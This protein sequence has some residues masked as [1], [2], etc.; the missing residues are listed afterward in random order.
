M[1]YFVIGDYTSGTGPANATRALLSAMPKET[2]SQSFKNRILRLIELYIKIPKADI[3]FL[4]GHSKQNLHALRIAARH[5]KPVFFWMHGCVE[6]ENAIN[7]CPDEDMNRVE[8][9]VLE[10]C[11]RILAVSESFEAWLK[12]NYPRYAG[13]IG[14]LSN[15]IFFDEPVSKKSPAKRDGACRLVS[16]G[17]GMPRKRIAVICRA[18]EK[19]NLEG[20]EC[21][22]KV[23]GEKGADS[24]L[25]EGAPFTQVMG[26]VGSEAFFTGLEESDIY[27]QNSCFETFG[28]AP[29][30]A[31]TRGCSLL[32]SKN[33]GA[34]GVFS[35]D[36]ITEGD[37]INDTEDA[38]E[39]AQRI[40]ELWE[41]PNHDRLLGAIDQKN[42][43]WSAVWRNLS[44]LG[45]EYIKA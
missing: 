24:Q 20:F 41:K 19:L 4:S 36:S 11:D 28:L 37:L 40:R 38:D 16:S 7:R 14:C 30:E 17:G 34:L 43:S 27:I 2:L 29:L 21:S 33:I 15:G 6:H 39:I 8:R 23:Y 13:K 32:L 26:A 18:V 44:K 35:S 5:K 42:H 25:I 10:E 9:R 45:D 31:L 3:C 22:L 12:D 1:R